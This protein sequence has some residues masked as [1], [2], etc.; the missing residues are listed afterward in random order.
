VVGTGFNAV[1]LSFVQWPI[2]SI[3]SH[4]L[5]C[6]TDNCQGGANYERAKR[7][8]AFQSSRPPNRGAPALTQPWTVLED[9]VRRECAGARCSLRGRILH[10]ACGWT[11]NC[12]SDSQ[13]VRWVWVSRLAMGD[14]LK[15]YGILPGLSAQTALLDAAKCDMCGTG[16]PP[17]D[18][19]SAGRNGFGLRPTSTLEIACGGFTCFTRVQLTRI[20]AMSHRGSLH[21]PFLGQQ[22][23]DGQ[24]NVLENHCTGWPR[25]CGASVDVRP[26]FPLQGCGFRG[27]RQG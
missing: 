17:N 9:R 26:H 21:C 12:F 18:V 19:N 15:V 2:E 6:G 24:R 11:S 13:R 5:V 7:D 4:G 27:V 10:D 8:S 25:N 20:S 14:G 1:A 23:R 3:C 22:L 16:L